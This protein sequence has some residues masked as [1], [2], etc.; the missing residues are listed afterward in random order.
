[1]T[2]PLRLRAARDGLDEGAGGAQETLFIRIQDR[3]QRDLRHIEPLSQQV[4][5]HQ[6][7][8]LAEAQ[9]ANDLHPFDSVDVGVQIT[10]PHLVIRQVFGQILRHPLGEGGDQHPLLHRHPFADLGE[11]VVHL[12]SDRTHLDLGVE[13]AGG[14]Y[15]LLHHVAA[16]LLQ[17]VGAGVAETNTVCGISASNSSNLSGRLSSAEGS[18]KPYSTRVSLRDLSL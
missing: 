2:F 15:H 8:E 9:I 14:A 4:D 17:L 6:H 18:R 10:H 5:P 11:Q 1:M 12:G 13:Q 3:H 16:G 7:V